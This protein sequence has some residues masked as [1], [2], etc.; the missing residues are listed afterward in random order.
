MKLINNG[1]SGGSGTSA[2]KR[3]EKCRL[4]VECKWESCQG[5]GDNNANRECGIDGEVKGTEDISLWESGARGCWSSKPEK[6]LKQLSVSLR[7]Q[8]K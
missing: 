4:S 6:S 5:E 8:R 2:G 3:G 1:R 7:K